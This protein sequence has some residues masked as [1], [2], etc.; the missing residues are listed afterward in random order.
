MARSLGFYFDWI[1]FQV[2]FGHSD[3]VHPGGACITQPRWMAARRILGGGQT[4]D[5]SF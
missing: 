4:H 1:N 3:R 5:V 2:V